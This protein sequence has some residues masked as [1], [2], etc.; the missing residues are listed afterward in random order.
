MCS[1]D[2][3]KD[4]STWALAIFIDWPDPVPDNEAA[5]VT[6]FSRCLLCFLLARSELSLRLRFASKF[7]VIKDI[8][9]GCSQR[10]KQ[11]LLGVVEAGEVAGGSTKLPLTD[12]TK[13]ADEA[14]WSHA[15]SCSSTVCIV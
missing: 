3:Y 11:A 1:T 8:K 7:T 13:P 12:S 15:C 14:C 2:D 9:D 10:L 6:K 5:K 4:L